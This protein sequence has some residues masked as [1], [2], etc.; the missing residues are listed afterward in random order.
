MKN[1]FDGLRKEFL[2]VFVRAYN[3]EGD[4]FLEAIKELD[5]TGLPEVLL[6]PL[7]PNKTADVDGLPIIPRMNSLQIK[8]NGSDGGYDSGIGSLNEELRQATIMLKKSEE[9]KQKMIS[10]HKSLRQKLLNAEE[11]IKQQAREHEEVVNEILSCPGGKIRQMENQLKENNDKVISFQLA[12]SII[13]TSIIQ[14][15]SNKLP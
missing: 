14:R 13:R 15:D 2:E 7:Q 5:Q 9:E 8:D 11:G 12:V 3:E 4:K 6:K 10:E 1:I